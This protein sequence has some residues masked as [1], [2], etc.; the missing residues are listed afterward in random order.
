MRLNDYFYYYYYKSIIGKV[1]INDIKIALLIKKK[2]DIKIALICKKT[3][4]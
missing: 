3:K 1:I 4:V 2:K